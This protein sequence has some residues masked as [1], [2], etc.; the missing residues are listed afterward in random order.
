MEYCKDYHK[1]QAH[2]HSKIDKQ[3]QSPAITVLQ[4]LALKSY[5][6]LETLLS[7]VLKIYEKS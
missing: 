5:H 2:T 6:P 4:R 1:N 7:S 3:M